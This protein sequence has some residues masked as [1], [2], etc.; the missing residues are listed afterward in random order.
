MTV[1]TNSPG[2]YNVTVQAGAPALTAPGIG[3]SIPISALKVRESGTSTFQPLS[4]AD[5]VPVHS[6]SGPSEQNGDPLSNDY[7]VDIP[8]VPS[9]GYSVTLDYIAATIQ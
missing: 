1:V 8:F 7:E 6:Q 3:A 9:G 5:P 2:G 4:A